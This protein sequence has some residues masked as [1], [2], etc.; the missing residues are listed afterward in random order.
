MKE[1]TD[2][3]QGFFQLPDDLFNIFEGICWLTFTIFECMI[4]KV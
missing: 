4:H 1:T 3:K 2:K